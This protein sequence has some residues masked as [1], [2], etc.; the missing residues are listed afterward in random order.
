LRLLAF[1]MLHYSFG[2]GTKC[3]VVPKNIRGCELL[4]ETG[5][6][7]LIRISQTNGTNSTFGTGHKK[8]AKAAGN[9]RVLDDNTAS[10]L[11]VGSRRHAQL[12]RSLFIK[13][14]AGTISSVVQCFC[15]SIP[16]FD[17]SLEAGQ[18]PTL[19]ILSRSHTHDLL[20]RAL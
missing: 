19:D 3:I 6:D 10:A 18:A 2:P 5:F 12:L 1:Q 13:S 8:P 20:E 15:D 14:A 16:R 7:F 4:S 17:I 11:E 9:Y